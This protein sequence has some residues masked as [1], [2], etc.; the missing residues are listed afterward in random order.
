[1]ILVNKNKYRVLCVILL[2]LSLVFLFSGISYSIFNY[3]GFGTTNNVIQTG[4]IVFSYS[5]A[6]GGGNGIFI[7]NAYP[8][9]DDMGKLLSGEREYFDFSVSAS[10]TNSNLAYEI[11]VKKGEESTLPEEYVKVYLTTF[12]GNREVETPLT[13]NG[14]SVIT[15][16]KLLDTNN[17]LLSGKTVYY[18]T[19]QAGEVAYGKK[20]RLRMWVKTPEQADFDYESISN[21]YFSLKVSV[22]ASSTY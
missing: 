15:Y 17:D 18:G 19:V 20:F 21:Q 7:E 4:K 16:N 14:S 10:V 6:N 12:E 22:A 3:L 1:M 5:D 13:L 9:P 11:A 8:I 2:F